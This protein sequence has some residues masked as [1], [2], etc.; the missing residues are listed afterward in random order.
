MDGKTTLIGGLAILLLLLETN[1][2]GVL[3]FQVATPGGTMIGLILLLLD[4]MERRTVN[5]H[6]VIVIMICRSTTQL[7]SPVTCTGTTQLG[8]NH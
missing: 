3:E 8:I 1:M 7:A 2:H 6:I 5:K 4:V